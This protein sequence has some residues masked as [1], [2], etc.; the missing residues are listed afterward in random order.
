MNHYQCHLSTIIESITATID[1]IKTTTPL[2]QPPPLSW[3]RESIKC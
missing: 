2:Q 3:Q 1:I